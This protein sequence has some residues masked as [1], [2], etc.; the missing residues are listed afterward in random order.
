[1]TS[2]RGCPAGATVGP[3]PVEVVGPHDLVRPGARQ[4]V[5]DVLRHPRHAARQ[6]PPGARGGNGGHR[7]LDPGLR[8]RPGRLPGARRPGLRPPVVAS[9]AVDPAVDGRSS[10]TCRPSPMTDRQPTTGVRV[11]NDGLHW[12][13]WM[14][15]SLLDPRPGKARSIGRSRRGPTATAPSGCSRSASMACCPPPPAPPC[16]STVP[17]RSSTGFSLRPAPVPGWIALY[18]APTTV[19]WPR[20]RSGGASTVATGPTGELLDSL[21]GGFRPRPGRC[22]GRGSAAGHRPGGHHDH[23]DDR[24]LRGGSIRE[25]AGSAARCVRVGHGLVAGAPQ[26]HRGERDPDDP[27]RLDGCK[28]AQE[29]EHDAD[30]LAQLE[31]SCVEPKRLRL[32]VM[33]GT[34]APSGDEQRGRAPGC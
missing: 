30:Q 34:S 4:L 7:H 12:S 3:G 16:S 10:C 31:Y 27:E 23:G 17:P 15:A 2:R 20:W 33:V 13:A 22:P 28:E 26:H 32:S 24:G 11:S 21:G 9:V 8:R 25:A 19:A 14:D 5:P 29:Q 6:V 1:M 18:G